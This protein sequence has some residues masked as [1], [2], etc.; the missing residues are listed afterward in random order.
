MKF[1]YLQEF[2]DQ[3]ADRQREFDEMAQREASALEEVHAM[4]TEYE[5]VI[6][7]SLAAGKDSTKALDALSEKIEA[8]VKTHARR[9]Q[10]REMYHFVI[11]PKINADD[12]VRKFNTEFAPQYKETLLDPVYARLLAAKQE[13]IEAVMSYHSVMGGFNNE[14]NLIRAETADK[15]YYSLVDIK[16]PTQAATDHYFVTTND[17]RYLEGRSRPDFNPERKFS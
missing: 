6:R 2:I 9:K 3:K 14:K 7:E 11:K 17:L 16:Y 5:K 10:E 13:L 15:H 12:V 8:A 1:D 4:K